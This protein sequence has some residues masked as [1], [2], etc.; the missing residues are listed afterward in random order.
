MF[1]IDIKDI[2]FVCGVFF[3]LIYW[4]TVRPKGQKNKQFQNILKQSSKSREFLSLLCNILIFEIG[5]AFALASFGGNL[6]DTISPTFQ[7]IIW[8]IWFT[9]GLMAG[10]IILILW[11]I[12]MTLWENRGKKDDSYDTGEAVSAKDIQTATKVIESMTNIEDVIIQNK[13]IILDKLRKE[14]SEDN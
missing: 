14:K 3:L 9:L 13:K 10:C 5:I 8:I 11:Q 1:N 12:L 6:M 7:T 4:I 2:L